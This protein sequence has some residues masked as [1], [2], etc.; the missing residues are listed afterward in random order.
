MSWSTSKQA[1]TE[2]SDVASRCSVSSRWVCPA[3][4]KPPRDTTKTDARSSCGSVSV[5]KR[6][7]SDGFST[8]VLSWWS[9]TRLNVTASQGIPRGS[10]L[11]P[12]LG[13]R[14]AAPPQAGG[15]LGAAHSRDVV[16]VPDDDEA[17]RRPRQTHVEPLA[18]AW[19]DLVLVHAQDDGPALE[20]L[21]AQDMAVEGHVVVPD[22]SPVGV[23]IVLGRVSLE[24][25]TR[26][27]GQQGHLPR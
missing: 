15:N 3:S 21:A 5:S 24:L 10:P 26:A 12:A 11:D 23:G 22:G 27:D 6:Y 13:H 20:P 8:V 25:V 1:T 9:Y 16:G 19:L 7:S 2:L 4:M 14:W 18:V 17:V